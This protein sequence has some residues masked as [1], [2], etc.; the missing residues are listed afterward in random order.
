MKKLLI[1]LLVVAMFSGCAGNVSEV[2]QPNDPDTDQ[3]EES[4]T[5]LVEE[6]FKFKVEEPVTLS[7]FVDEFWWPYSDWSGDMPKWFTEMTNIDFDVTVAADT[8]EL[9]M[10][11]ASGTLQDIVVTTQFNMLA[12]SDLCYAWDDL[13]EEYNIDYAIH[14][15]YKFVNSASDDK[16]Y[17]IRVG[18]SADYEYEKYPTVNPEG[19]AL[20]LR[21]DIL[22]AVL[23][24]TGLEAITTVEELEKCFDAC[25]ELY[26]DVVPFTIH[27][28]NQATRYLEAVY[29]AGHAGLVDIDDEAMVYIYDEKYKTVLLKM[30]E[31]VSKGYI[32]PENFSWNGLSIAMEKAAASQVFAMASL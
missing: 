2:N 27:D 5:D 28:S 12:N 11:V 18:W 1:L 13:I 21:K 8:T 25:K 16:V 15:A 9:S 30:N 6:T 17:T 7:M 23:N 4:D 31:W 22:E 24:E 32:E 14:P 3:L 20:V 19:T 10:L 29:G 26:P